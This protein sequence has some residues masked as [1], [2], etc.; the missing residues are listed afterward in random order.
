MFIIGNDIVHN[1]MCSV[2]YRN[3][4]T[5]DQISRRARGQASSMHWLPY[6]E[7]TLLLFIF[8]QG[9]F[10]LQAVLCDSLRPWEACNFLVCWLHSLHYGAS[11]LWFFVVDVFRF[12]SELMKTHREWFKLLHLARSLSKVLPFYLF[13]IFPGIVEF[14]TVSCCLCH[15]V[16]LRV[17]LLLSLIHAS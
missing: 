3:R 9:F 2:D 11:V 13:I 12:F 8:L 14:E 10:F 17:C 4:P 16:G 15:K 6:N 7:E 1:Q 5:L